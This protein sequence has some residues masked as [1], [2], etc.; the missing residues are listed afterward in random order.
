MELMPVYIIIKVK[1]LEEAKEALSQ[2]KEIKEANPNEE[3]KTTIKIG[4]VD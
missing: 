4:L 2:L 1:T 3:I